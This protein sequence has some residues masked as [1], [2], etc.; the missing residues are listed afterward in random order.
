MAFS[1]FISIL[2][3]RWKLALAVV[4]MIVGTAVVVSLLLP[5]QY[6][7]T[8][9]VV[10]DIGPDPLSAAAF[11]TALPAYMATQIDIL[12]SERVARRVVAALQLTENGELRRKRMEATG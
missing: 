10:L 9:S 7:A 8:A 5:K 6:S 2:H 4:L 11:G 12:Q 3:A 1:Q